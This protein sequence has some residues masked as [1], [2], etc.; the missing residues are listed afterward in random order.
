ML[1]RRLFAT[2]KK[3]G[4]RGAR[5]CA[6]LEAQRCAAEA[7]CFIH[8]ITLPVILPPQRYTYAAAISASMRARYAAIFARYWRY[9]CASCR[10]TARPRCL[11]LIRHAD[12]GGALSLISAATRCLMM[13]PCVAVA[14]FAIFRVEG[15][16]FCEPRYA[17]RR[18]C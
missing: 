8:V 9:G 4:S 14:T 17:L 2:V 11:L 7:R 5:I 1:Q 3:G 13:P 10:D 15:Y 16:A 6:L 18:L 12:A